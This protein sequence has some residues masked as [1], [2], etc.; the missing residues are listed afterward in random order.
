MSAFPIALP[1]PSIEILRWLRG[2]KG[3]PRLALPRDSG[4]LRDLVKT[5]P[6]V[7]PRQWVDWLRMLDNEKA[8]EVRLFTAAYGGAC[9]ISNLYGPWYSPL[10]AGKEVHEMMR[11]WDYIIRLVFSKKPWGGRTINT[12]RSSESESRF[13]EGP[14]LLRRFCEFMRKTQP[15]YPDLVPEYSRLVSP[16]LRITECGRTLL[17]LRDSGEPDSPRT[18]RKA[19]KD[20]GRLLP[21]DVQRGMVLDWIKR[22]PRKRWQGTL[23]ELQAELANRETGIGL[24]LSPATLSR[25]LRGSGLWDK[26]PD[27]SQLHRRHR[28]GGT[29]AVAKPDEPV[30]QTDASIMP[31]DD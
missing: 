4:T 11:N 21:K 9:R 12:R 31:D 29:E 13:I 10:H 3:D 17:A 24:D 16:R 22:L 1:G 5:Q 19:G 28:S 2:Q 14:D 15:D 18:R 26:T 25:Y 23:K 7:S 30:E 8:I 20:D 27:S 6:G